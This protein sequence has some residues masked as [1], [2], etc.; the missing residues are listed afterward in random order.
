MAVCPETPSRAVLAPL[1]VF[2]DVQPVR[3]VDVA[4]RHYDEP[5]C[6]TMPTIWP[7]EA[8]PR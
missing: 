4:E 6:S 1:G 3:C 2:A 7:H 8:L 5:G